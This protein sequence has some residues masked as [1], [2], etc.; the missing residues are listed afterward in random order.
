[1][2][3][4]FR[5]GVHPKEHKELSRD[6]PLRWFDPKGDLVYPLSQHIGKPAKAVVKKNDPVLVGQ[7]I[8]EAD[9][10]V[11]APICCGCSGKVKAIEKR[12]IISGALAECIVIENDGQY[13]PVEGMGVE[14]DLADLTN[15]EILECVQKAGIVGLGGAGF[16]THVK[17]SPKNPDA[18]KYV[19]ANGAECEPYLTCN[20]QLMREFADDIVAGL[21]LILRLFPN[22]EGVIGIEQ[23]KPEAIAAMQ[24][25]C[26]GKA[27][28]RVLPLQTKYPQGGEHNLIKVIAGA[29]YPVAKLPADMG[30]IVDN[31]GTI[32]A[33]WRAV[34]FNEPLFSHCFTL[35]GDAVKNP[36]NY[37]IR[38]GTSLAEVIE[39]SGGLKDGVTLKKALAGGPMMGFAISDLSAPAQK[40]T[41]GLTLLSEDGAEIALLKQTACLRCG[42][43]TTVCPT[44][45]L[46]ELMAAAAQKGD[47]ER[48]EKTLYGLECVACGSCSYICPAKRPLTETFKAVKAEI[49]ARKRAAQAGGGK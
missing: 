24:K 3:N 34:R 22:A 30:C 1:M 12:R 18:I 13:T 4:T 33:I 2:K 16:P 8:A 29:D 44:G 48:Y 46:P 21:E 47:Y 19:I 11:S 10:F 26:A 14:R 41:N 9:G 20:D 38:D 6:I 40:T 45:L 36:G 7:C 35:T 43:C 27:R 15:K 17:L 31:V 39:A 5:G 32:Y 37:I 28:V 25:A 49:M 42:R 23:N